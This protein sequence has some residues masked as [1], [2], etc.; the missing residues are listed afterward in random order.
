MSK[1]SLSTT[2]FAVIML[3]GL[4]FANSAEAFSIK[5]PGFMGGQETK[6]E[7]ERENR[8]GEVEREDRRG[9]KE[10]DRPGIRMMVGQGIT[11]TV[12][13]V[14]ATTITVN[15]KHASTT[16]SFVV[17]VATSKFFKNSATT[18]LASILVGDNVFVQGKVTG[19]SAIAVAVY[20]GKLPAALQKVEIRKEERKENRQE[21]RE[22]RIADRIKGSAI[23]GIVTSVNGSTIM[24]DGKMGTSTATTTYTVDTTNA[25]IFK[26]KATTTVS[27]ILT[28]DK[29]LVE[30]TVSGTSVT[31]NFIYDGKLPLNGKA[32]GA[33][34]EE[35]IRGKFAEKINNFFKKFFRRDK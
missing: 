6:R 11:G 8:Q 23:L 1:K 34:A 21:K 35:P 13:A 27:A 16:G 22:N 9:E 29:V 20:D 33:F 17:D 26:D 14:S 30:G 31:A 10:D 12:T 24:V 4:G 28:G 19:T 18:T 3:F 15:G 2:L 7:S 32:L 25:K 5:L